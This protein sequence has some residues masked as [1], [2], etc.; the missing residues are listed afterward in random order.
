[1]VDL[2]LEKFFDRVNH[3][4]V[5]ARVAR[6]VSDAR[7]LK[8]IRRFLTAGMMQ[9][10]VVS[11]SSPP[12]PI[13]CWYTYEEWLIAPIESGFWPGIGIP[14]RWSLPLESR[15]CLSWLR[16]LAALVVL[17]LAKNK[18]LARNTQLS[19]IRPADS[20][21]KGTM[22]TQAVPTTQN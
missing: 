21:A 20:L 15:S 22:Q 17:G 3:D 5:M 14:P 19:L 16:W 12:Y 13:P 18:V 2:D 9:D 7:V 8:L 1:M 4:V 11:A 10:G 6:Q